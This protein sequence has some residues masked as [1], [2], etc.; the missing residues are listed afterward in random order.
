ML[1]LVATPI[2]NLGDITYR[3][4][5][6]LKSC[7]L[8]LCEDTRHSLKLLNHYEI[9]V[10]LKSYHKFNESASIDQLIETLKN[11]QKISLISDAGTP[12]ISDPGF[13]LV[14]RCI[15]ENI[16]FTALPG[17]CAAIQGLLL[18]GFSA[19]KFQ[20]LG[21][22]PKG[23]NELKERVMEMLHYSGV[24]ICY[25]SPERILNTFKVL[26][27][28]SPNSLVAMAREMTKKFEECLRGTAVSLF[29]KL[30]N[31]P[32]KGEFVLLVQGNFG[33][34]FKQLS[35]EEHV[36]SL[37]EKFGLS[38][39]EAIQ[40]AAKMRSVSKRSVYQAFIK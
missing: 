26:S 9:K 8:I 31:S 29:E 32:I 15:L 3:A 39:K 22:L 35:L 11:G 28:L 6:I 40:M 36:H 27:E 1:F 18:S 13:K 30:K 17:P 14:E 7:D 16:A 2:G 25:E 5:E 20:F 19:E 38:L 10:P 4:V 37:R 12:L 23:K 33:F 21:F 24:S 34:D